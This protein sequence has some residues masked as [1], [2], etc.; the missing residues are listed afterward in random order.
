[1]L[2]FYI[3]YIEGITFKLSPNYTLKLNVCKQMS[4][5][6]ANS[7]HRGIKI[8][9]SYYK[10]LDS[11]NPKSQKGKDEKNRDFYFVNRYLERGSERGSDP[12]NK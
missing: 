1:M 9:Q 4:I 8:Y 11:S 12:V 7:E 3:I 6:V 2:H 10:L 5:S